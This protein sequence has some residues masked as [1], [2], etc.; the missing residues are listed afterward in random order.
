M[1]FVIVVED[2]APIRASPRSRLSTRDRDLDDA[3]AVF[4]R[5]G[6]MLDVAVVDTEISTLAD[7][8]T[9]WDVRG[10]WAALR[11]RIGGCV[12]GAEC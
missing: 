3:A 4:E 6:P 7:S 12:R 11:S 2:E 1:A 5:S 8:I 10:R 9:E